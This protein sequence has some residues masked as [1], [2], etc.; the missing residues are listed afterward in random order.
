MFAMK[1]I[2]ALEKEIRALEG[3]QIYSMERTV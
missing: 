3:W 2:P 1:N